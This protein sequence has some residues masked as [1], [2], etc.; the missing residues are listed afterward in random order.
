MK[1]KQ[2]KPIKE[3]GFDE[4]FKILAKHFF[5][6][7]S[8]VITDFEIIK[9]PKKTD[10]LVIETEKPIKKHVRIFDYFKKFNIIEFK[11]ILD[12]FRIYEDLPKILIY[13]GGLLLNDRK[14]NLV[15]TTFTIFCSRKP[16]KLLLAYKNHIQK[17]KNG[18]YLIK[19]IVQVPVYVV[20]SNEVKGILDKELALIKEF[21]TGKERTRFIEEILYEVLKGDQSLAEYLYFAFSLYR[22]DVNNIIEKEGVNMTIVE[23]NIEAWNEQLGLKDKYKKEGI[24]EG[25]IEDAKTMIKKEYNIEEIC[26]ITGLGKEKV[27]KLKEEMGM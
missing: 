8:K 9:L 25:K 11:S 18:V 26:D 5:G 6:E 16:E 13:I 4:S 17:V 3:I 12:P 22:G 24:K 23:K 10:V 2:E 14:A 15:N 27:E 19:D 1:E 7:F 20:L 21:S